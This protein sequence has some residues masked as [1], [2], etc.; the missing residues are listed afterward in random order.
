MSRVHHISRT[1]LTL[2]E[3]DENAFLLIEP[4]SP[5]PPPSSSPSSLITQMTSVVYNLMLTS[6][7]MPVI[8]PY[9]IC[10]YVLE[11]LYFLTHPA[12]PRRQSTQTRVYLLQKNHMNVWKK[13]EILHGEEEKRVLGNKLALLHTS[14]PKNILRKELLEDRSELDGSEGGYS[15]GTQQS[16]QEKVDH[17]LHKPFSPK[18]EKS[19]RALKHLCNS[20]LIA[21]DN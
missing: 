2:V 19:T 16:V 18:E 4:T 9:T 12:N 17:L 11:R 8:V 13:Q 10:G 7:L 5:P 14:V 6:M 21:R 1:S 15:E 20:L 3:L